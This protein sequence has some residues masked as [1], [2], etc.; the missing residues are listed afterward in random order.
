MAVLTDREW[1]RIYAKAWT[2]PAFRKLLETDPTQAIKAY[3][4]EVGK[5]FP[6][7]VRLERRPKKKK[8]EDLTSIHP[9]PPSCC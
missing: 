4:R 8:D 2:D 1:G 5:T 6:K 7:I 9:F 3:G